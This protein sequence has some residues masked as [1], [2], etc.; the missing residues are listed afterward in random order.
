MTWVRRRE[1]VHQASTVHKY[2]LGGKSVFSVVGVIVATA[3]ATGVSAPGSP[4]IPNNRRTRR[5]DSESDDYVC[6][7]GINA[8]PF[9][10]ESTS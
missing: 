4:T 7:S 5:T 2:N 1:K 10:S 8:K 3:L 9:V 6:G